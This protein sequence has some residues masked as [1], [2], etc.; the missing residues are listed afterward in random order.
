MYEI[1]EFWD[2]FNEV[3]PEII[4][5]I[6]SLTKK[7][8]VSISDIKN[9]T[10][11]W[12]EPAK[13]YFGLDGNFQKT[14]SEKAKMSVHPD[15]KELYR[16]GFNERIKGINLDKRFEY[17]IETKPGVY[18]RISAKCDI[19][20]D[21]TGENRFLVSRYKNHGI[22][23]EI[24][25]VTGLHT[26]AEASKAI[27]RLMEEKRP[28]IFVKIGLE[29]FSRVNVLYGAEYADAILNAVGQQLILNRTD[30]GFVYRMQG[31]KFLVVFEDMPFDEI[32]AIYKNMADALFN[33]I[34]IDGKH[35]PLRI[36]G[37]AFRMIPQ[38]SEANVVKSRLTYAQER[39]KYFAH[40]NLVIYNEEASNGENFNF[41][42]IKTIHRDAID[43]K[44]GFFL[45]YQPIVD[46]ATDGIKGM[47]ALIR[48]KDDEHGVVSPA[49]FI[50]WLEE[51]V[52]IYDLGNWVLDTA[53]R[54]CKRIAEKYPDFFV[55]VNV[56]P[57]QLENVEFRNA[58]V[59]RLHNSGLMPH[60]LCIEFTER[61]RRLDTELLRREAECFKSFG[62][63]VALDD[64]GT[65]T[66]SLAIAMDMP[67]DEIKIDMNFVKEIESK[68]F[69]QALVKSIVDFSNRMNMDSCIEGIENT[70]LRDYLSQY[71]ATFYQG[72]L[73]S[74][75][76]PI[77]E[78]EKMMNVHNG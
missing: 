17:R 34:F 76:V 73:Y 15:D 38:K 19:I 23:E 48:W 37:G 63:R 60:Q 50:E 56:C 40:G 31:A 65:G 6:T 68:P 47:E 12:S 1:T 46:S 20:K 70:E 3:Y 36:S 49:T 66:S 11:W 22:A 54:D 42:L 59:T 58:V 43:N 7:E 78:F 45:C 27:D 41:N 33:N 53:L 71:G 39:S 74:R 67:L 29:Q 30:K 24:D 77:D 55:N 14:A 5:A 57:N 69:N 16:N 18:S 35:V 44:N 64:F 52:C 13:D 75:P 32:R 21:E 25:S 28:G 10:T 9:H 2:Q 51:D 8:Y 26:E 62:I 4:K 72:Y 61:C